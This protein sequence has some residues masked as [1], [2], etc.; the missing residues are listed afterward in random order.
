[1]AIRLLARLLNSLRRAAP[2]QPRALRRRGRAREPPGDIGRRGC[3]GGVDLDLFAVRSRRPALGTG[4][5]DAAGRRRPE[6]RPGVSGRT[7]CLDHR[8]SRAGRRGAGQ[9]GATRDRC[10]RRGIPDAR[11]RHPR[12]WPAG[13][14]HRPRARGLETLLVLGSDLDDSWAWLRAGEALER[15]LLE[16]TRAGWVSSPVNQALE[17]PHTRARVQA[18]FAGTVRPQVMLRVGRAEP[19]PHTPRRPMSDL[20]TEDH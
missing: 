7:A 18:V 9:L 4:R 13:R 12:Q 16:I 5:V 10:H 17:L 19:T 8:R 1:M 2:H 11:L 14:A 20:L 6:R 3:R 15:V